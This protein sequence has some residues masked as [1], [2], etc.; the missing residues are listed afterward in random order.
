[1]AKGGK[2]KSKPMEGSNMSTFLESDLDAET[3][4][5]AYAR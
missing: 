5:K 1:M 3:I 2:I 4:T